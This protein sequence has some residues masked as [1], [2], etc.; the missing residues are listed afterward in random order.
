MRYLSLIHIFDG[1]GITITSD[2]YVSPS[3]HKIHKK[4]I[5]PDET[6]KL[7]SKKSLNQLSEKED[8]QLQSAIKYLKQ[9]IK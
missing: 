9:N 4:G 5:T 8:N 1:S 3:G 2:E 6:V 7:D